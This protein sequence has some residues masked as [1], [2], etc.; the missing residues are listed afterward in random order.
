MYLFSN[1]NLFNNFTISTCTSFSLLSRRFLVR[2]LQKLQ[3]SFRNVQQCKRV[4][5]TPCRL[6]QHK[7][8][9]MYT[10]SNKEKLT[11]YILATAQAV[12]PCS[13]SYR[14]GNTWLSLHHTST[15]NIM[16]PIFI[17]SD[18]CKGRFQVSYNFTKLNIS[19]VNFRGYS[20]TVSMIFITQILCKCCS[21]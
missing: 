7:L 10:I 13:S 5:L 3:R 6:S 2:A 18:D 21:P 20:E 17:V 11:C 4:T 15:G 19:L 12:G 14:E 8:H 9:Y 16:H 1:N